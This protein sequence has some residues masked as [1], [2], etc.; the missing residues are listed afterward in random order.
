MERTAGRGIEALRARS[1]NSISKHNSTL[2]SEALLDVLT[3]LRALLL[4]DDAAPRQSFD[5][6]GFRSYLTAQGKTRRTTKDIVN[7][8]RRFGH[9]LE[10]GG[11]DASVLMTLSPRNKHHAMTALA[12]LAKFQGCYDEWMQI[13][14]RYNLRWSKGVDAMAAFEKFFDPSM[15]VEA[16]IARVKAMIH[17]LPPHMGKV[18]RFAA[19]TGLRPS[20]AC[21]SVMLLNNNSGGGKKGLPI[22]TPLT[23][24]PNGE[25]VSLIGETLNYYNQEQ[26]CLEHFRFPAQFLRQTKKAYLSFITLDNLQPIVNLGGKSPSWNAIR[27]QC[28]V[29]GVKMEMHLTRKI[30]ASHLS[31]C[32]IQSEVIDFLQGRVSPRS[33]A[34]ITCGRKRT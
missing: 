20:E 15:S 27:S 26:Q 29:R 12:N 11:E 2:P 34:G 16:M 31:A 5:A 24:S 17:V 9:V 21:E 10:S 13:K 8:A 28:S 33:L 23:L 1:F 18:V 22:G 3:T 7:Y 32:G 30:F 4:N 14:R 19:I 25:K 6:A